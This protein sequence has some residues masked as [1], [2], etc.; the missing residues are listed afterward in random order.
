VGV[1]A[2]ANPGVAERMLSTETTMVSHR[3]HRLG[4]HSPAAPTRPSTPSSTPRSSTTKAYTD[5]TYPICT[6]VRGRNVLG[7]TRRSEP[8]RG[9]GRPCSPSWEEFAHGEEQARKRECDE[10]DLV[11]VLFAGRQSAYEVCCPEDWVVP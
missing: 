2:K 6:R 5:S 4:V 8:S 11:D 7:S 10:H 3:A 9:R 1:G